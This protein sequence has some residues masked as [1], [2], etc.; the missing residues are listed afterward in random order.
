MK[1]IWNIIKENSANVVFTVIFIMMFGVGGLKA[2]YIIGTVLI[3]GVVAGFGWQ[4]WMNN[5]K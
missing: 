1:K 4:L 2:L 3:C 5:K